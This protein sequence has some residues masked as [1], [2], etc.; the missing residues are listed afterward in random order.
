[1]CIRRSERII[2]FFF[3]PLF[4]CGGLVFSPFISLRRASRRISDWRIGYFGELFFFPFPRPP[5][6]SR[7]YKKEELRKTGCF[8]SSPSFPLPDPRFSFFFLRTPKVLKD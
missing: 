7:L 3:F 5:G 2:T 1:M 8:I 4:L 6:R